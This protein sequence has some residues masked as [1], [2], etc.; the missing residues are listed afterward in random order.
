[1]SD[2]EPAYL[3]AIKQQ[4]QR[5]KSTA[6][7]QPAATA[8]RPTQSPAER[9]AVRWARAAAGREVQVAPSLHG[10]K[11]AILF[12]PRSP[13]GRAPIT[14]AGVPSREALISRLQVASM[15]GENVLGCY[16]VTT[17][18]P[19]TVSTVEGKTT[20]TPGAPRMLLKSMSPEQMIRKATAEAERL[21]KT[22]KS[23][24]GDSRG[25]S[26]AGGSKSGRGR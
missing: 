15:D 4:Q 18:R 5:K 13:D 22:R 6:A 16:E 11:C 17:G 25:R 26:G 7:P 1:M 14:L 8:A 2:D 19:L 9:E 3:K 23:G 12:Q 21:A 20:F 24:D 10:A